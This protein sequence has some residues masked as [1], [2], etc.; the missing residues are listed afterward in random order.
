MQ[1]SQRRYDIIK[2]VSKSERKRKIDV[3]K[4]EIKKAILKLKNGKTADEYG[5]RAEHIKH[6]G[7]EA[8][9]AY[10]TIFK[11]ILEEGKVAKSFKTGVIT[12]VL[13]KGKNAM[14]TENYRGIT[15]TSIHGKVFEYVLIEKAKIRKMNQSN[16]QFGFTEG[17]SPN[18][19]SLILSEVCSEITGKN[20]LLFITTLDS[21]KAFDVVNHQILLDKMYFLGMDIQFWDIIEDLYEDITSTVKWQ[22]DQ[23]FSFRIEQ[24]VRQGG[25]LSTHL[26]KQYINELLCNLEKHGIG[27]SIGNITQ[28]ALHV[29]TISSYSHMIIQKCKKCWTPCIHIISAGDHRFQIHPVKSNTI[30][31]NITKQ[32]S[33][34][35]NN[36]LDSLKLGQNDIDIN[37]ETTHLGLK[38]TTSDDSKINVDERITLARRTLYSLIKSGVHGTNGLNPRTSVKIYQIYVIPRLLYGLETIHIQ[39]KDMVSLCSFHLSTLKHLQS[40]PNRTATSAVYLLVGALPIAA[41]I[42]KRQLS[43]L[44]SIAMSDNMSIREIARRQHISGKPTSFLC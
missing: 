1:N 16:M 25:V 20:K 9:I 22:G 41:E 10:Q 26:Y 40:L 13:K 32:K 38:R 8:L 30:I 33:E 5:I 34:N 14:Y 15:V 27:I 39:N 11:Q 21:Q 28:D 3:S 7:D 37:S 23:S 43:L 4:D 35:F 42:H 6:T 44:H 2:K 18:M 17:L 24:G 19:A 36:N 31:K 12:P 29:L